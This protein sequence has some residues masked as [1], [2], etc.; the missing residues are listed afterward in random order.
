VQAQLAN[1][2]RARESTG[3][4]SNDIVEALVA[5]HDGDFEHAAA[6]AEEMAAPRGMARGERASS[7][8]SGAYFK[9]QIALRENHPDQALADFQEALRHWVH[10][11]DPLWLEDCLGDA[12]LQ[13][14]R[15][16]EA[17]QEYQRALRLFPGMGL[18]R[19]HL[20]EAYRR[21][22]DRP[23]AAVEYRKFLDLW[24]QAD[25]GIP[26]VIAARAQLAN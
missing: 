3:G 1:W 16:E 14:G 25:P 24:S 4:E 13:L 6:A 8:R 9:G 17:V 22:G 26:E 23:R 21:K 7:R 20:A 11:S 18:A 19:F 12:Y 5:L 2:D 10:W 15:L